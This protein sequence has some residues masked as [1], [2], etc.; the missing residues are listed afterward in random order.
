MKKQL[1]LASIMIAVLAACKKNS[2][3]CAPCETYEVTE[4]VSGPAG[5]DID[6]E[7][8]NLK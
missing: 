5:W 7:Q 3:S 4:R 6:E 8:L 1:V 2:H